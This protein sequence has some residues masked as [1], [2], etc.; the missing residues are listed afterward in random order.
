MG[1]C[2]ETYV[3][4]EDECTLTYKTSWIKNNGYHGLMIWE[5]SSDQTLNR[6]FPLMN[7]IKKA[8]IGQPIDVKSCPRDGGTMTPDF[9]AVAPKT[10]PN[11]KPPTKAPTTK[12][13][14]TAPT[15]QA[16][17]NANTGTGNTG[18]T[19]TGNTGTGNTGTGNTGT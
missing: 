14:T 19:G 18:N 13:P 10:C 17:A 15:Q 12:A 1:D 8:M 5:V 11:K 2:K 6:E 9:D 4:F 3:S 7:A 16:N